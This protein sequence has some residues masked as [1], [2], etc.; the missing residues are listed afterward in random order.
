MLHILVI[1]GQWVS[2]TVCYELYYFRDTIYSFF[3][4]NFLQSIQIHDNF[5]NNMYIV[6][7]KVVM[8]RG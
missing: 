6:P 3:Y 1:T 2:G 4:F 7:L 5:G 8:A